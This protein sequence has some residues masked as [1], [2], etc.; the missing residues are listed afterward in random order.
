MTSAEELIAKAILA[1]HD[2]QCLTA[3]QLR[4]VAHYHAER[5]VAAA[6]AGDPHAEK[7]REAL[8]VVLDEF[9]RRSVD[10]DPQVPGLEK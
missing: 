4:L 6:L 9:Q 5:W 8:D 7:A 3:H 1:T 10:V 2:V